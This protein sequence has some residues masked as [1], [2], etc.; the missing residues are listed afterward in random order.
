MSDGRTDSLSL[1]MF[2][3]PRRHSPV[4][5]VSEQP[6]TR[7]ENSSGAVSKL[8]YNGH[9]NTFS[10]HSCTFH[11]ISNITLKSFTCHVLPPGISRHDIRC[12]ASTQAVTLYR[13]QYLFGSFH[14]VH[15]LAILTLLRCTSKLLQKLKVCLA[16]PS[17]FKMSRNLV[18]IAFLL[19]CL[20]VA[21]PSTSR[22]SVV[23]G[24]LNY[25]SCQVHCVYTF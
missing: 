19:E 17:A 10:S 16:G 11:F 5:A 13:T 15:I 20:L 8:D 1:F 18:L 24:L 6:M 21:A 2:L 9:R 22:Y 7:L 25:L 3:H 4:T 23:T 12:P 14:V